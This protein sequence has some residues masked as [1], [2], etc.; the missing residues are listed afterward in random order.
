ML[1]ASAVIPL[2]GGSFIFLAVLFFL[3]DAAPDSAAPSIR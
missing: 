3:D 2:A 1:A